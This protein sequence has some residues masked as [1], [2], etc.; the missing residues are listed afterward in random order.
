MVEDYI[1]KDF[2][3]LVKKYGR[4]AVAKSVAVTLITEEGASV[5]EVV[6]FTGLSRNYIVRM[7]RLHRIL[8]KV[9]K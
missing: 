8:G 6:K 3:D 4:E 1:I 9:R 7:R 5:D 2:P